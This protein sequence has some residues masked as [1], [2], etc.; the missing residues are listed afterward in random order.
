[1]MGVIRIA[2][3]DGGAYI[4]IATSY[5]GLGRTAD[6]LRYYAQ[7][8]ELEPTWKTTGNL[9][10]EYG[11]TLVR[12]GDETA[13]RSVFDLA[14]EKPEGKGLA[15]RSLGWLALYHGQYRAARTS[16]EAALLHY[17]AIKAPL[18]EARQHFL[19]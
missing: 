17:T 5:S 11:F 19:L 4:N 15:Q 13:A 1:Y 8:F 7:A 16:F 3:K 6:A 10:H 14:L 18:S 2:P 12:N 9:N